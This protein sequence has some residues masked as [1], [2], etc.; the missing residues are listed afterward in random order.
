[1]FII[2]NGEIFDGTGKPSFKADILI[3]ADTISAIGDF[4]RVSHSNVIDARGARVLPGF[5]D[6]NTGSDHYLTLLTDPFQ[7]NFLRQG[8]TSI[9]GGQC[10]SSLAPLITGSL[11]SIRK[12][13]DTNTVNL[14]WRTMGEFLGVLEKK[15]I[16]VNFGT[17]I[18]HSTIR[19]ALVGHVERDLTHKEIIL[20]KHLIQQ[21][22]SEGALGFSTGLGYAHGRGVSYN[23]IKSLAEV[24]K[25]TGGVY[26]THLR[27]EHSGI[28]A[29]VEETLTLARETNVPTLINHFR[30]F[31]GFE[32]E[33]TESLRLLEAVNST[34]S[35]WFN[36]YPSSGSLVPIYTLLPE[37]AKKG[38]LEDMQR[39]LTHPEICSRIEKEFQAIR[40]GDIRIIQSLHAPYL[41]GKTLGD[42]VRGRG[43]SIAAGLVKLMQTTGLRAIVLYK[44]CNRDLA[45][46][47]LMSPKALVAS[48]A[49]SFPS[50]T[51]FENE[52]DHGVF[53]NYLNLMEYLRYMPFEKAVERI[54][55][56][57][58]DLFG[59][60]GRGVLRENNRADLVI[61]RERA[62]SDVFINGAHAVEAGRVLPV[63]AGEILRMKN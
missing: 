1:M 44:N 26:A 24:L 17:L 63:Y 21:G 45:I 19:R 36:S 18:G 53:P 14:G 49:P 16:G 60:S 56:I 46:Q 3:K 6:V 11:E 58:A 10:G 40:G 39:F 29:A 8:V 47:S 50:E 20:F 32:T 51:E 59:L 48:N 38:S 27:D 2:K 41:I 13:A 22:M 9:I 5:I 31:R 61:M 43:E 15:K 23:E 30:P 25:E 37:W 4:S 35:V 62:V 12:W 7:E 42:F 33:Y 57:P 34:F 55:K 54:T 52:D 28:V